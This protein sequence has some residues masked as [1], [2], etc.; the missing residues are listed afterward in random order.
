MDAGSGVAREALGF[1]TGVFMAR[2]GVGRTSAE[3]SADFTEDLT[4]GATEGIPG[5]FGAGAIV[6]GRLAVLPEAR[7]TCRRQ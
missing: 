6:P 4:G 1:V 5:E 3:V 7:T 2:G